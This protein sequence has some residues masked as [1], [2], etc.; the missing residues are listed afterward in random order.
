MNIKLFNRILELAG[1][2]FLKES[3]KDR[4]DETYAEYVSERT[5]EEPFFIRDRKYQYCNCKYSDGKID[6]GVYSFTGDICYGYT[7]FQKYILGEKDA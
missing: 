5:D 1:Q 4:D 3:A 7:Y 2:K 6:I